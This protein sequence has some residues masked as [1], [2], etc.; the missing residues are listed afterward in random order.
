MTVKE[1]MMKVSEDLAAFPKG[2]NTELKEV[3]RRDGRDLFDRKQK[4]V[5]MLTIREPDAD[6]DFVVSVYRTLEKAKAEMEED[7]RETIDHRYDGVAEAEVLTRDGER[8]AKIGDE[9]D[10]QITHETLFE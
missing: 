5:W 10:W 7:I 1:A 8:H 9:V 2:W 3:F 6:N 4:K